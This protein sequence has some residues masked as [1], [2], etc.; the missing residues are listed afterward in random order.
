M[1]IIIITGCR[2]IF[3]VTLRISI[4]G[5]RRERRVGPMLTVC[6]TLR[7]LS[8]MNSVRTSTEVVKASSMYPEVN[9]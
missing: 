8:V 9:A 4:V 5:S 2:F 1:V 7:K 3:E 6:L